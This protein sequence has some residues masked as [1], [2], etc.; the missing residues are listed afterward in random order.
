MDGVKQRAMARLNG[1]T[2]FLKIYLTALRILHSKQTW[3]GWIPLTQPQYSP[4]FTCKYC[5]TFLNNIAKHVKTLF[6]RRRDIYKCKLHK[7]FYVKL[8]VAAEKM[9]AATSLRALLLLVWLLVG[10]FMSDKS[11]RGA[12]QS[13]SY[14]APETLRR[15]L[16]CRAKLC[17]AR[18]YA[19]SS[20]LYTDV[21]R[22]CSN[23]S[24]Q[25][26]SRVLI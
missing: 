10:H 14:M 5:A 1:P 13:V 3:H 24:C 19:C 18:C 4:T 20:H 23:A 22:I 8:S 25:L 2:K 12:K 21:S 9:G 11:A 6:C 16:V 17:V 26:V 7:I 15:E